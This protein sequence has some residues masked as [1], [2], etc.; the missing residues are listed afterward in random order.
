MVDPYRIRFLVYTIA[1]YYLANQPIYAAFIIGVMLAEV[2]RLKIN[3]NISNNLSLFA[4][5]SLL[6]ALALV[7][8]LPGS[9][10]FVILC[11]SSAATACAAFSDVARTFLSNR[12]SRFLASISF[13]LYILHGAVI[14]SFGA[15]L[16]RFATSLG[17][18]V[19]FDFLTIAVALLAAWI[20][21]WIDT[22]GIW[23]SRYIGKATVSNLRPSLQLLVSLTNQE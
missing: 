16:Q 15:W 8:I 1:L 18:V 9:T 14:F 10:V 22:I 20:F 12:C 4:S 6:P 2:H 3:S 11:V 19:L 21:R 17:H 5:W 13:S 7:A 23:T